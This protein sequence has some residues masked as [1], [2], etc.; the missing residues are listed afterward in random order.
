[1]YTL[2]YKIAMILSMRTRSSISNMLAVMC[3]CVDAHL[4][5]STIVNCA[6]GTAQAVCDKTVKVVRRSA[7]LE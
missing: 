3:I 2:R 4:S 6:G 5:N 1:M 7:V